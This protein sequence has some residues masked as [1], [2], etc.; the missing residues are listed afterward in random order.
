MIQGGDFTLGD[1]R[2]VA[3]VYLGNLGC[4]TNRGCNRTIIT[5]D[6]SR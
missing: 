1:G 3:R 6:S 2:E 4:A 5:E